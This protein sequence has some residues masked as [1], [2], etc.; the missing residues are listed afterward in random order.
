MRQQATREL[1]AY[2]NAIRRERAAPDRAEIDPAS[3]R[4][5][6][7]DTFMLETEG[8]SAFSLRLTG[9]RLNALWLTE[10]KGRSFVDLWGEDQ[11]SVTAALWTVMDGAVPVVIGASA[12]PRD[13]RPA[14]LELLLLPLRHHGR[15]HARILGALACANTPDWLGLIA[16]ERFVLKSMRIMSAS[17]A[18]VDL[19]ILRRSTAPERRAARAQLRVVPGGLGQA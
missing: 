16:V 11:A 14:E 6:L 2:W 19:P 7:S 8:D 13:R 18:R 1:Y 3:I 5:I 17:N 10:M 12:A 9:A 4:T 15:T